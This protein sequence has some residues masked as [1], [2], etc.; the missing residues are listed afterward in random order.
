MRLFRRQVMNNSFP[1]AY[2]VDGGTLRANTPS[3]VKRPADD[4]LFDALIDREFCYILTPRQM[5]KSSLMIRT[6]QRLR[7]HNIKTATVD[8]QGI[9]TDKVKEWYASLLSQIRR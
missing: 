4:E 9:G 2:F 6:S 7:E 5:G 1:A 8:I 3:Y